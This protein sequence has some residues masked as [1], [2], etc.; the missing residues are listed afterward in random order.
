MLAYRLTEW[1]KPAK[2]CDIPIPEPDPG[3]VLINVGGAGVCQSDLH[4]MYDYDSSH[5][6]FRDVE[7]PFT[8]GHENAGWITALGPKVTGWEIG[9]PVVCATPG[10]G[11]CKNCV[12]GLMTYCETGGP[13]PGI[14]HDGGLAE[15]MAISASAL[16]ALENLEPWQAAPLTDA[17][18]TSY[19]AI[20][21]VIYTLT[22]DSTVVVIGVGGLGHMAVA[23]LREVCA[24][25]IV[26]VDR[27]DQA[28]ALA[29]ELGADLV[30]PS[31]DSTAAEI[32]AFTKRRGA[33]AVLDF[34]G[35]TST[36]QLAAEVARPLGRIVIVGLGGGRFEFAEGT[37]PYGCSM[38]IIM[39][40]SRSDMMEVVALAEAGRISARI[41][42]YSLDEVASVMAK[43]Q[44]GDI[45]G[46]AVI[47]PHS[48]PQ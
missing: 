29:K 17:G 1:Q 14:G 20:K 30:V 8:L 31:D 11:R 2:L 33:Q 47:T 32:A 24:A 13:E 38:E 40:G 46:R 6:L 45:V 39:G 27:S 36:M 48:G 28:L 41:T 37:V 3:E 21:R 16:I 23:I 10:C 5:P 34:V 4:I 42:Q 7:L 22:P 19:S 44:Q 43:L 15:F 35:T 18:H 12:Q 26:A 9:Q 25:K